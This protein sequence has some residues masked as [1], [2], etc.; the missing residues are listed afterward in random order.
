MTFKDVTEA[1]YDVQNIKVLNADGSD[2]VANN[3]VK[4]NKLAAE[5]EYGSTYN[6]RQSKGGWCNGATYISTNV[7]TFADGEGVA[8]LN[9]DTTD[10]YLQVSGAVNLSPVSMTVP[11]ASYSIIGNMTPATVDIQSVIPYIGESICSNNNKIK[12]NKIGADGEYGATY[13]WR[14]AKGGWCTGAT[15]IGTGVL[16]LAPGE[17]VAVYNGEDAGITLKFPS[18]ISE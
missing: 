6:Y 15:F 14:Q 4:I 3:K 11:A 5:G 12:I 8:L 9:G 16:S 1:T 2:Y 7:L 10:L 13:N 18:P 17:A